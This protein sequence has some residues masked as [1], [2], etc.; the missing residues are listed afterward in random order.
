MKWTNL[1]QAMEV[2]QANLSITPRDILSFNSSFIQE[3]IERQND[4]T[5]TIS[6]KFDPA[7]E[8]NSTLHNK[9]IDD[10]GANMTACSQK[11]GLIC[12]AD[13]PKIKYGKRKS[14]PANIHESVDKTF[15]LSKNDLF[16]NEVIKLFK[17]S[18]D[19]KFQNKF[20]P[21]E[22][23]EYQ[24]KN[25][26]R[27]SMLVFLPDEQNI[28]KYKNYRKPSIITDANIKHH[29]T[30]GKKEIRNTSLQDNSLCNDMRN[31]EQLNDYETSS[32]LKCNAHRSTK[33]YQIKNDVCFLDQTHDIVDNG[34]SET[35]LPAIVDITTV[36]TAKALLSCDAS[37]AAQTHGLRDAASLVSDDCD[38]EELIDVVSLDSPVKV[39]AQAFGQ[40]WKIDAA[41]NTI[42]IG[43]LFFASLTLH[44][45]VK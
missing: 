34:N 13:Y 5:Q 35:F 3:K 37:C 24:E 1:P 33:T 39:R 21:R 20:L 41:R 32:I 6:F 10:L 2:L 19:Q 26:N 31:I 4:E 40:D 25:N 28:Y 12:F 7:D 44:V 23:L 9:Y 15:I 22:V 29:C 16:D 43:K 8:A 18:M 14:P 36:E 17:A 38:A 45:C 27:N 42:I 30:S 11:T